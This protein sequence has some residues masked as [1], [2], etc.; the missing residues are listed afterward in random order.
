[1][2]EAQL[3]ALLEGART[4]RDAVSDLEEVLLAALADECRS[5]SAGLPAERGLDEWFIL[6]ELAEWLKVGK[7]TAYGLVRKQHIPAH[8]IG[9]AIRVRRRD[10]ERWLEDRS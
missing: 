2:N 9:R 7:S 4:V 5:P 8:R 3:K 1:M 6:A 10:V